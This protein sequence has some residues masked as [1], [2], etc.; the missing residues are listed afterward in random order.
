MAS[1]QW[2]QIATSAGYALQMSSNLYFPEA[3]DSASIQLD[4]VSG[5]E[6][7]PFPVS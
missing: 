5:L 2:S 1:N 3:G 7:S 4:E 6:M